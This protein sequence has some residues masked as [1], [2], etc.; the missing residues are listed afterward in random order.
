[1][2]TF[3]PISEPGAPRPV[4]GGVLRAAPAPGSDGGTSG[5]GPDPMAYEVWEA[6]DDVWVDLY[7]AEGAA[8]VRLN[9][10]TVT[11]LGLVVDRHAPDPVVQSVGVGVH[12]G[13]ISI[14]LRQEWPLGFVVAV[15]LV[16]FALAAAVTAAVGAQR[17]LT[18]L[19]VLASREA[20]SRE[21]ERARVAREIHDGPL[22]DL[23]LLARS[24]AHD[25]DRLRTVGSD[26]RALAAD[27]RPPALDRLGL[28]AALDDL[29]GR[30]ASAPDPLDVRVDARSAFRLPPPIE[31]AL[32]RTAQ[33]ALA[34]AARHGRARTAWVFLLDRHGSDG[35]GLNGPHRRVCV[36]EDAIELVV[37]DDG[38]GLPRSVALGSAGE[39]RL[40]AAGHFGL[41]GMS[42]RARA[43]GASLSVGPGPGGSGTEVRVAVPRRM[44][45][46]AFEPQ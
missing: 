41:V 7:L 40:L 1:M 18:R 27:L 46:A 6:G 31:L 19:Q 44:T 4:A 35:H 42:E 43:I 2:V 37:R 23:A 8:P 17:R 30:W 38:A 24:G 22:Q 28:A 12:D 26:L 14:A 10:A 13:A 5:L 34:N 20:A 21:A 39:R 9:A 15:A 11:A 33:E 29:A 45:I 25:P 16:F 32:Y 3:G 36:G